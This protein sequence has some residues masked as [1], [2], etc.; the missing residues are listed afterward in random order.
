MCRGKAPGIEMG[1][2]GTAEQV[3]NQISAAGREEGE[4]EPVRRAQPWGPRGGKAQ[5]KG[6][7]ASTG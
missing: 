1:D 4:S 5:W 3:S 7:R 6:E 2:K